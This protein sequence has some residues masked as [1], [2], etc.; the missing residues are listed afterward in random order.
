MESWEVFGPFWMDDESSGG[1]ESCKLPMI[2][3]AIST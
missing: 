1:F 2:G 3:M